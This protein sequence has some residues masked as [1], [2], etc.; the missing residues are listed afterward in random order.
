MVVEVER[1]PVEILAAA[2]GRIAAASDLREALGELA[3]AAVAAARADVAVLRILGEDGTLVA[4]GIAPEGSALAAEVAGAR[5]PVERLAAGEPSDAAERAARRVRAADIYALPAVSADAVVGSVELIR[6]GG[7]LGDEERAAAA[8]VAAQLA[9]LVRALRPA[10][11]AGGG[12]AQRWA[13]ELAGD[14]LAAGSDPRLAADQALRAAVEAT[15]ARGGAVWGLG[16]ARPELLASLGP[17]HAAL[18]RAAEIVAETTASWRPVAVERDARLPDEAPCAVTLAL[19]EPPFAVL[20]L[21]YREDQVPLDD[22]LGALTAFAARTAH[23]LR[24][25]QRSAEVA[26]ELE[27]V[28]TL[29][30]VV[31]ETTSRLS[32]AYTLETGIERIASVLPVERVGVYLSEDGTLFPAAGRGLVSGHADL[33]ERLFE[34]ALGPLR[35]RATI[36]AD[37]RGRDPALAPARAALRALGQ[38]RL[39]AVP[40]RVRGESIGLLVAYPAAGGLSGRDV[41]LLA[42]LAAQLAVAAQNAR[43]HERA[44]ELG[45]ALGASLESERQASRQVAALYEISRSFAQTLSLEATL[46]AVT[47]TL[48]RE[49]GVDAAVIRVPDERGDQLVPR[50][51]HVVE[52]RLADPVR[53]ILEHPQRRPGRIR[54]PQLLDLRTVAKIGGAHALLR[55]FLEKGSTAALLPIATPSELLAELTILSLDPESPISGETLATARTIARQAALAIDNARLYSQQKRFAETMQRSLLPRE[56]PEVAGLDVGHV[57]E[58]AA[59]VD[60]GGDVY[61]FL[62]LPDGRLAVVL[63][64][65]TG[66]GI[67]ATADMAMA[68]FTF[69]SL[70]REH[71]E[72]SEFLAH[73]NDVVVDEIALGKFITM[74]YL[75]VDPRGEVVCA[76]AG[77]P[78]PRVVRPDGAVEAVPCGGIALGIDAPQAYDHVRVSLDAGAAVV[79]YTDGVIECRSGREL[80]GM[81]RLDA[82]LAEHAGGTAQQ[83]ADAVLAACR[84]FAGGDLPDDCAVVVIRRAA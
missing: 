11:T 8:L 15:R 26:V 53:A 48:V 40:L 83:L 29:L 45:Q 3:R 63:G 42:A 44:T 60:V 68:K 32:L 5:A 18:G 51:V 58:S 49:L 62:E 25:G 22:E 9:L 81:E 37:V 39:V 78:E 50:S 14:S 70:A 59:Q 7:P 69:R 84:G 47:E 4:R 57:Y 76:S 21:F 30:E 17:V 56:Q 61:D 52:S 67:D 46:E 66:H 55:P 74:V 16:E 31:G 20:Q 13:L 23:A 41:S 77:H 71:S 33:A 2:A 27:Q 19:G 75:T 6:V 38:E 28:R 65:V 64:D 1:L 79:L 12:E 35:A 82:T 80:F 34:A 73:A 36:E 24:S 43:L 54:G 10:G 72:P